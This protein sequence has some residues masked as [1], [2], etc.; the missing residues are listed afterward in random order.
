MKT[1]PSS[2]AAETRFARFPDPASLAAL[3]AWYEGLSSR[4][5]VGRYLV[6]DKADGQSS[7]SM[8]SGIRRQLA[9]FA[10]S[11]HRNDLVELFKG[12][13]ATRQTR[14]RAVSQAIELLPGLLVPQPLIGDDVAQWLE[15]RTARA[16]HAHGIKTLAA[17]TVRIPR[18]RRWWGTIPGLGA[19]SAR[20]VEEFFNSYPELTERA[21]AL[22][23]VAEPQDIMPWERLSLPQ[24]LD[25]SRGTFRAPRA[26]CTLTA[27]NDY[28]AVQSWLG[29]H[30]SPATQ[31]AYKKEA[32]RLILWAIVARGQP[33]S[34][35]TTEDAVAYR[36]FLRHPSP[37]GRWV[38]PP[39]PRS[40]PEWRPFAGDLSARSM[41]YSLSVLGAMYRWLIQQRYVLANPFAGLKVRG[42]SRTAPLAATRVF[43]ETEWSMIQTVSEGL[44]WSYGWARPAAQ[45]LRFVLD[46]AYSTGLRAS[47]LVGALLG[48]IRVDAEG[49]HWLHLVGKGSKPGTVSLPPLARAAL[50]RYLVQRGLPTTPSFWVPTTPLVGRL[51]QDVGVGITATRLWSIMRRFFT[52]VADVIHEQSPTL[53]EKLRRASPHW[54]RHTHA[55]HALARGAE[56]T[57]VRDNLRHASL[58]TTSIYL[59]GD[60]IKRARQ[61]G[62]AFAM[63]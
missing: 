7:R 47:E 58:S 33:L 36:T 60:D 44:E 49:D 22:I 56:L 18:R 38:G 5:A 51:E 27:N 50:D 11:R 45:R 6:H 53:A 54:M 63:K 46:F 35:L 20:R 14:A 12:P 34:S 43:T 40:S 61:L 13:E 28:D 3:R 4:E 57:T 42:A 25:G 31:R 24:E 29:L 59:H 52:D 10:R 55:T 48:M 62:A 30:E 8:L 17:L 26:T 9:D 23:A 2:P 37:R 32:E 39:R 19:A 41:A 1:C 16:L 21:H 15:L